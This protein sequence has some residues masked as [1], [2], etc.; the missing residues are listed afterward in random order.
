MAEEGESL[1]SLVIQTFHVGRPPSG[2]KMSKEGFF[3]NEN[4]ED[5]RIV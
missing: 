4:A 2:G 3:Y 5:G 1:K